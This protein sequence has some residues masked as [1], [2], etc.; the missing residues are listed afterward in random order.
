MTTKLTVQVA[1]EHENNLLRA[2]IPMYEEVLDE[3]IQVGAFLTQL[4]QIMAQ[5]VAIRKEGAAVD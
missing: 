5:F 4:G 1:I 2:V 3:A